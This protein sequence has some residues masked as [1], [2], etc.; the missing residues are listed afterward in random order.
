MRTLSIRLSAEE[1]AQIR[2][3]MALAGEK[4]LGPHIKRVYFEKLRP[5]EGILPELRRNTEMTL[6]M[7]A[8]INGASADRDQAPPTK[9]VDR[10]LELRLLAAIFWMLHTSISKDAKA[11]I[12]RYIDPDAVFRFLQSSGKEDV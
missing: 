8:T 2:R 10:D 12:G 1:E 3:Q 7:L 4:D 6:Q 11:L 5:G 9:G